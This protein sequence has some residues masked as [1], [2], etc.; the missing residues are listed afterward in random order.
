MGSTHTPGMPSFSTF[1]IFNQ[2]REIASAYAG[3]RILQ[4]AL[5]LTNDD[6]GGHAFRA[7]STLIG[8]N[9]IQWIR[10]L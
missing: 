5:K 2:I 4:I 6:K 9:W 3:F 10:H 1:L 7:I 8:Y